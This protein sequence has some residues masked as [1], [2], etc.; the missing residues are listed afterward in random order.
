MRSE[1]PTRPA[2]SDTEQVILRQHRIARVAKRL[3]APEAL[4]DAT[5]RIVARAWRRLIGSGPRA[6]TEWHRS[7]AM[8]IECIADTLPREV[9][10]RMNRRRRAENSS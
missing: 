4:H 9:G 10:G 3:L 5:P 6:E 8:Q 2:L 1:A 7:M